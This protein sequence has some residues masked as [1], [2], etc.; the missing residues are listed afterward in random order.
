MFESQVDGHADERRREDD[1]ADLHLKGVFVPGVRVKQGAANI[2]YK[3]SLVNT[4]S[5]HIPISSLQNKNFNLPTVSST[6]PH[7]IAAPYVHV[8]FHTPKPAAAMVHSPK[9]RAK[10]MLLPRLGM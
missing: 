10:K 9:N 2:T 6:N 7:V 4:S 8:R 5:H 3:S 1:G